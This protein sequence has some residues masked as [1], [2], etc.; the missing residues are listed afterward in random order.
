MEK[1]K[2]GKKVKAVV[3][4]KVKNNLNEFT[5]EKL[6]EDCTKTTKIIDKLQ[7]EI[8]NVDILVNSNKLKIEE[9]KERIKLLDELKKQVF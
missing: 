5:K 3:A 7:K 1:S 2:A 9:L 4:E 6:N 8:D